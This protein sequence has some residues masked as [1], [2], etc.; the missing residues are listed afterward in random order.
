MKKPHEETWTVDGCIIMHRREDGQKAAREV[1]AHAAPDMARALQYADDALHTQGYTDS[2]VAR[3]LIRE[4]L[5]KA[6][7]PLP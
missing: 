4:A 2:S 3:T 5:L 1:L 6:G 7:V